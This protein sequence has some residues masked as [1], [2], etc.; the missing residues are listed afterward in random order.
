MPRKP[1]SGKSK[2]G[3][4]TGQGVGAAAGGAAGHDSDQESESWVAGMDWIVLDSRHR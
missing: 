4:P 3:A 2:S 1:T